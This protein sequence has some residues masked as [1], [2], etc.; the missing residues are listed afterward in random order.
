MSSTLTL[1]VSP[2]ERISRRVVNV[3]PRQLRDVDE[4]VDAVEVDERAEVDDVRDLA[5]DD[6]TR[7]EA[8]EDP[9][10]VLLALLLEHRATREDDVVA[11]AVELDHLALDLLAHVL[12]EIR[13]T[14]DI[15][16]RSRQE[17]ADAEVDDE[18]A[19]DDLDH[20]TDDGLA[21]LGRSL[22]PA[23]RLLEAGALLGEDQASVLVLLGKDE[24]VDLLAEGDLVAGIDG[25]ADRQLGRGDDALG[26]VADVDQN[27]V[28]VD[29]DDVAGDDV[30][31]R[32]RVERGVV[33]GDDLAVDLE[34]KT[35]RTFDDLGVRLIGGGES[36]VL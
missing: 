27:L 33:I 28:V 6:L 9:L 1:T 16:E 21:R 17:T 5:L 20:G 4:A 32:E 12:V 30:T 10:A 3:R 13:H 2:I 19:L 15:D 18:T 24:R 34:Q 26:L 11:R 31:L 35:V 8:V 7:L 36:K 23:P 29:P 14:A 22:D 25:L